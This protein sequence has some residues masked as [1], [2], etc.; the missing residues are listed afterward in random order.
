MKKPTKKSKLKSSEMP[1]N[2]RK[3]D[4]CSCCNYYE[5]DSKQGYFCTKYRNKQIASFCVCE[6]FVMEN[7]GEPV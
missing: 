6:S 3:A 2:F 1:K 5:Y 4:C 7:E